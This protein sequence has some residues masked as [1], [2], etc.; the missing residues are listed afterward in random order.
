MY[1]PRATPHVQ[2]FSPGPSSTTLTSYAAWAA[3]A[4][5][6]NDDHAG[7]I[8]VVRPDD[9]VSKIAPLD[10]FIVESGKL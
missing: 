2:R 9:Y 10:G 1:S 6:D 8:I 7:A 4:T 3:D 5:Y